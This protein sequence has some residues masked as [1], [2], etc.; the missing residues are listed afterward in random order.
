MV[1]PTPTEYF[2]P[3]NDLGCRI[4]NHLWHNW[5]SDYASL[6]G[7][8]VDLYSVN[9]PLIEALLSDKSLQICWTRLWRNS[10]GRLFE[11]A[12]DPSDSLATIPSNVATEVAKAHENGTM[13]EEPKLLFKWAPD[14]K[15][16]I[17]PFFD[18]LPVGSDAW[19][20]HKG[21]ISVTPL[22][23]TFA[24]PPCMGEAD[25]EKI[26]WKMKL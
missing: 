17:N 2:E 6:E 1:Y 14:M 25:L 18:T 3:A 24:E 9:I 20:I 4:I 26:V 11:N 19:A 15:A 22:R 8:G 21:W 7:G 13:I 23:S 10:Y 12:V 5:G 16:L